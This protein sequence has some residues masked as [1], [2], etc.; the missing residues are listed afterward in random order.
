MCWSPTGHILFH[1]TLGTVGIWALPFSPRR[2]GFV[3]SP[4][5]ITPDAT[6][7]SVSESGTL[8]YSLQWEGT[9]GRLAWTD[10]TGKIVR[11]VSETLEGVVNVTVSPD[12]RRAGLAIS[13]GDDIN[14]W[15]IDLETGVKNRLTLDS[16]TF[17]DPT[18][19]PDGKTLYYRKI[20]RGV[21][22][23]PT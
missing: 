2:K 3:G 20:G 18:F 23:L 7:P 1:R 10:H 21:F 16:G 12:F 22:A 6:S 17:V 4:F 19:S 8:V 11:Y 15:V 13:S 9:A 5:L 14:L